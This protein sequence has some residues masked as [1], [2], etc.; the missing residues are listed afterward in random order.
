MK[1]YRTLA[2]NGVVVAVTALLTWASGIDWTQHVSP[3][4]AMIVVG[5][6][7]IGLRI[8]TTTPVGKGPAA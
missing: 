2:F 7:N 4:T 3:T 8:L 5:A 6:V 1:G